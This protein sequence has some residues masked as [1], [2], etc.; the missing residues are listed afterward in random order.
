MKFASNRDV[1]LFAGQGSNSHWKAPEAATTARQLLQPKHAQIFDLLLSTCRDAFTSELESATAEERS[2][3]PKMLENPECLL[4]PPSENHSHP[5]LETVSLYMHQILELILYESQPNGKRCV[6]EVAGIC[7]G[8]LPA[9]LAASFG[10]FDSVAFITTAVEGFRVAFWIGMRASIYARSIER[11]NWQR[12]SCLLTVFGSNTQ[13]V[14]EVLDACV[15]DH[16]VCLCRV[17]FTLSFTSF[18]ST[19]HFAPFIKY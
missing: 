13:K 14:Q 8:I 3:F 17:L 2:I 9:I 4:F 5:L 6:A 11:D 1:L 12:T 7:T 19:V 10:S 18:P 16:D 15:N